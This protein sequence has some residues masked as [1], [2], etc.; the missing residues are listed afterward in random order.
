MEP[1]RSL[2]PNAGRKLPVTEELAERIIV[3]PTGPNLPEEA[4]TVVGDVCQLLSRR[5]AGTVLSDN[6][7]RLRNVS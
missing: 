1:Y 7:L 5:A 3:L 2:Q 4:L 6:K